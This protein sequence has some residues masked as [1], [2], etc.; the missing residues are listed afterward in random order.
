M[1]AFLFASS[2]KKGTAPPRDTPTTESITEVVQT[3]EGPARYFRPAFAASIVN[4]LGTKG[5]EIADRN[6]D[7][8]MYR[9]GPYGTAAQAV[10]AGAVNMG[11]AV[12][13][14]VNLWVPDGKEQ[15]LFIAPLNKRST[16]ARTGSGVAVLLDKERLTTPVNVPPGPEPVPP[17]PMPPSPYPVPPGPFP[18]VPPGPVPSVPPIG[19]PPI[20]PTPPAGDKVG[21]CISVIDAGMPATTKQLTCNMLYSTGTTPAA[22]DLAAQAFDLQGYPIAANMCRTRAAELRGGGTPVPPGPTPPGPTPP[23]A[24]ATHPF[25]IR[26]GDIPYYLAIYYTGDGSRVKEILAA[27]PNMKAVTKDGVTHY[28]PWNVGSIIQLPGS[29]P[30]A[31]KPLPKPGSTTA[32]TTPYVVPT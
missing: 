23:V 19:I 18:T 1:G 9:L 25:R 26:S 14:T 27:N 10:M 16:L 13:T 8:L 3:P 31:S 21:A 24:M 6:G 17:G 11:Y 4:V 5:S 30:V 28:T 15:F 2:K 12:F 32:S 22:L 20:G 7:I 29:W